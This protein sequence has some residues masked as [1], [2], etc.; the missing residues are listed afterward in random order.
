MRPYYNE[1]QDWCHSHFAD[2][3]VIE[4]DSEIKN[5]QIKAINTKRGRRRDTIYTITNNL[6]NN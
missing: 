3:Q 6:F 5:L 4:I 1:I 2:E